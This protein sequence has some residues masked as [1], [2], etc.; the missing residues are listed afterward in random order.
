MQVGSGVKVVFQA[1]A[2]ACPLLGGLVLNQAAYCPR[3]TSVASMANPGT[4][5]EVA[6]QRVGPV[7]SFHSDSCARHVGLPVLPP[8]AELPPKPL[9]PPVA[10]LP[11]VLL[12]PPAEDIPPVADVLPPTMVEPLVLPPP[13]EAPPRLLAV[14]PANPPAVFPALPVETVAEVPPLAITPPVPTAPPEAAVSPARGCAPSIPGP[15]SGSWGVVV[16]PAEP[17]CRAPNP[18]PPQPKGTNR[19]VPIRK[20]AAPSVLFIASLSSTANLARTPA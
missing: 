19:A 3:V 17:S 18:L 7:L 13:P 10:E 5:T 6:T 16:V 12:V 2:V 20:T 9:V 8:L 15:P 1:H 14:E 11:P 4:D